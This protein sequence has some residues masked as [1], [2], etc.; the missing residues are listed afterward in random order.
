[1]Y[2]DQYGTMV[3]PRPAT[4]AMFKTY[5]IYYYSIKTNFESSLTKP[6]LE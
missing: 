2:E 1:M 6:E 3:G 5:S 4:I